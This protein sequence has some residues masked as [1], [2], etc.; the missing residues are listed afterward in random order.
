MVLVSSLAQR[1]Q[2]SIIAPIVVH[3]TNHTKT[4]NICSDE[5]W[6][7]VALISVTLKPVI[8]LLLCITVRTCSLASAVL[9]RPTLLSPP[10][11][12]CQI[13]N[14]QVETS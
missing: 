2:K 10:A 3:L 12:A 4:Y 13:Y 11:A 7:R 9:S 5:R 14:S 8:V 1:S 6:L